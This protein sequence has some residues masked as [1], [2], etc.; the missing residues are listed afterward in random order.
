MDSLTDTGSQI[1]EHGTR[2][3]SITA[4]NT[5]TAQQREQQR[6]LKSLSRYVGWRDRV[7]LS[8][9]AIFTLLIQ[10]RGSV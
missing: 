8:L 3:K 4:N 1:A 7:L 9:V 2:M 10:L 6:G 5:V